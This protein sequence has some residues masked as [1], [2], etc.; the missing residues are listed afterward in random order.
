[1]PTYS[2]I[3]NKYEEDQGGMQ[4]GLQQA[5]SSA[6]SVGRA[7]QTRDDESFVNGA[8]EGVGTLIGLG[9]RSARMSQQNAKIEAINQAIKTSSTQMD[10]GL[11]AEAIATTTKGSSR[12]KFPFCGFSFWRQPVS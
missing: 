10:Q 5:G 1:M 11:Y 12:N 3:K 4:Q 9:I 6:R 2:E 7:I 8:A